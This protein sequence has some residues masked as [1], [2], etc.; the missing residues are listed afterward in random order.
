M[1]NMQTLLVLLSL[2]GAIALAPL[3]ALAAGTPQKF[4]TDTVQFGKSGSS[5]NKDLIFGTQ[6]RMRFNTTASQLEFSNDGSSF[7]SVGS[8]GGG[9]GGVAI[10]GSLNGDF[11]A[12][13]LNWTQAGGA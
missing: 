9:G 2:T 8:G 11:E 13:A 12:G 5:A 3:K 4:S 6:A 7:R 10:N 1:K